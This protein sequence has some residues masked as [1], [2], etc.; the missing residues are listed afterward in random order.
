MKL[1][2]TTVCLAALGISG[3]STVPGGTPT[4]SPVAAQTEQQAFDFVC[5]TLL[6]G[7]LDPIA[8]TFNAQ[9]QSYYADAKAICEVGSILTP[10]Q[11]AAD[12]IIIEPIIAHYLSP[13]KAAKAH[14]L[15]ATLSHK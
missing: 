5:P 14:H 4:I 1:A 15:A 9:V 6:S 11:F 10:C 3:C 2:I 8:A 12:F 7:A 13:A